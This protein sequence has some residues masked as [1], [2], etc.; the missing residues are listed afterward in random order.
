MQLR[1]PGGGQVL[2]HIGKNLPQHQKIAGA[3]G[4]IDIAHGFAF[5]TASHEASQKVAVGELVCIKKT[6]AHGGNGAVAGGKP[7]FFQIVRHVAADLPL[8][9]IRA[10]IELK[11]FSAQKLLHQHL[12][13]LGKKAGAGGD[14][15]LRGKRDALI[16][17]RQ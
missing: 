5:D 11:I 16:D 8:G 4:Y 3:G 9:G 7:A 12:L 13:S 10:A 2:Q 17:P 6:G 15:F 1:P 14:I